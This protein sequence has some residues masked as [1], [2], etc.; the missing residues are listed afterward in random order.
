M[1]H[2][3]YYHKQQPNGMAESPDTNLSITRSP[4][5]DGII[6]ARHAIG[7]VAIGRQVVPAT[8][9]LGG[10]VIDAT[11]NARLKRNI[12]LANTGINF[13]TTAATEGIFVATAVF[14]G[15]V[16]VEQIGLAIKD[17]SDNIN[18]RY[19]QQLNGSRVN[20]LNSGGAYVD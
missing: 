3:I 19:N 10:A 5:T 1:A 4:K 13:I 14:I 7:I 17:R 11:G 18:Q 20:Q 15:S 2:E 8:K 12:E 9:Q 6:S 16:V